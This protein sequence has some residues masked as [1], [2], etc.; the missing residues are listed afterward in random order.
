MPLLPPFERRREWSLRHPILA[1]M[2][3]SVLLSA[4]FVGLTFIYKRSAILSLGVALPIGMVL[5]TA[6]MYVG[7]RRGR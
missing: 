3:F 6:G 5:G 7:I 2:I 4:V 1:S